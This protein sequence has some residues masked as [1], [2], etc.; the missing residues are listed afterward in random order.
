MAGQGGNMTVKTLLARLRYHEERVAAL[1]LVLGELTTVAK[2]KAPDVIAQALTLDRV[3][4]GRGRPPRTTPPP[5]PAAYRERMARVKANR[6][7]LAALDPT[8]PT[9]LARLT[10]LGVARVGPYVNH[11]WL[12]KKGAGYVPTAKAIAAAKADREEE[13]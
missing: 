2:A 12:K 7:M 9:P 3:R 5:P 11:G 6:A 13:Q 8:T 10:E 1:R 4:R